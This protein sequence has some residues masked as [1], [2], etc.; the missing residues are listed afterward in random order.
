MQK[1]LDDVVHFGR[2]EQRSRQRRG[3]GRGQRKETPG[4]S[5]FTQR[6][7]EKQLNSALESRSTEGRCLKLLVRAAREGGR[8]HQRLGDRCGLSNFASCTRVT[9]LL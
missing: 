4:L 3:D 8:L 7:T 6:R 5:L 2:V 9:R 1:R